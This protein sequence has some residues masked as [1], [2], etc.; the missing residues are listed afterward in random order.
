MSDQ[1]LIEQF[2]RCQV[3]QD[4]EQWEVLALLYFQRGYLLNARRCFE[5]AES[6]RIVSVETEPA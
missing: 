5:L 3:W 4:P 2:Q 1:E 6:C